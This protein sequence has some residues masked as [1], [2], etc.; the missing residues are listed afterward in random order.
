MRNLSGDT[1]DAFCEDAMTSCC[2]VTTSE[3]V[4]VTCENC[5]AYSLD[6]ITS[7]GCT[8]CWPWIL[9]VTSCDKTPAHLVLCCMCCGYCCWPFMKI[10][11]SSV[12]FYTRTSIIGSHHVRV[13]YVKRP[14]EKR[15]LQSFVVWAYGNWQLKRVF[16]KTWRHYLAHANASFAL[17]C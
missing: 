15:H 8:N 2:D 7:C 10:V 6:V 5:T 11:T 13:H 3:T 9:N 4:I 12:S 1:D 16:I 14:A 17:L